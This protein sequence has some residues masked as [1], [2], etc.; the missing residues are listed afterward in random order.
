MYSDPKKAGSTL[1]ILDGARL[2][3]LSTPYTS[4]GSLSLGTAGLFAFN[5]QQIGLRLKAL[6][7]LAACIPPGLSKNS[8]P[9][10]SAQREMTLQWPF[11]PQHPS[12]HTSPWRASVL[13]RRQADPGDCGGLPDQGKRGGGADCRRP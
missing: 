4:F 12:L 11:H 13:C 2:Q 8:V 10:S 1:A 6:T 9:L 3:E 7:F 5:L